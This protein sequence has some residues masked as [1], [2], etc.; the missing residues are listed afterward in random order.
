MGTIKMDCTYFVYVDTCNDFP[1]RET[2]RIFLFVF[3]FFFFLFCFFLYFL[4][5]SIRS[6]Q[7]ENVQTKITNRTMELYSS[8]SFERIL[9]LVNEWKYIERDISDRIKF[10]GMESSNVNFT[11]DDLPSLITWIRREGEIVRSKTAN[12]V[13]IF[14]SRTIKGTRRVRHSDLSRGSRL[15]NQLILRIRKGK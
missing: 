15:K 13:K 10:A 5:R 4:K 8:N 2:M 9:K 3:L 11:L 1:K 12:K 6:L 14:I 7:K